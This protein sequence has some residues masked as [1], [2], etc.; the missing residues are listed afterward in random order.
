MLNNAYAYESQSSD[1]EP[2]ESRTINNRQARVPTAYV[3]L[4]S[5]LPYFRLLFNI[6][7][8]RN[9]GVWYT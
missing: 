3:H 2:N 8:K 9:T 7:N 4:Y 5:V 6:V 1:L